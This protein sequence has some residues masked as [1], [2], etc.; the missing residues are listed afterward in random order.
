MNQVERVKAPKGPSNLKRPPKRPLTIKIDKKRGLMNNKNR[1]KD[2]R[3]ILILSSGVAAGIFY[4]PFS[5]EWQ[6]MKT[7]LEVTTRKSH[8]NEDNRDIKH[9]EKKLMTK[10]WEVQSVGSEILSFVKPIRSYVH[11]EQNDSVFNS[12]RNFSNF[13][14]LIHFILDPLLK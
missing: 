3:S 5:H 2:A 8:E 12:L 4:H 1:R 11:L 13:L 10:V 9:N 6:T 14:L 7:K